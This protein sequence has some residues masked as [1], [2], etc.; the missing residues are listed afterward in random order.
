VAK[1]EKRGFL[2]QTLKL[3]V[4][5]VLLNILLVLWL[6]MLLDLFLSYAHLCD[7]KKYKLASVMHAHRVN[8]AERVLVQLGRFG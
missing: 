2:K 6:L 1:I 7:S 3:V 5:V 4:L 8:I